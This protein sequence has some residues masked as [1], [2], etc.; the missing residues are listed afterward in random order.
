[1]RYNQNSGYGKDFFSD[2]AMGITGK[3]FIVGNASGVDIDFIRDIAKFD[4]DGKI[5][6]NTTIETALTQCV[7]SRGDVIFVLPGYTE[8][9]TTALT[10][11]VAG[12]K[13][14]GLGQGTLRPALTS[15]GTIDCVDIT[16]DNV[17]FAGFHFPAPETDASTSAINVAGA[18]GVIIRDITG[19]G[20]QTAK[21]VV[22]MITVV[23]SSNDLLIEGVR[24]YNTTVAVNS[25]LSLEGA[26][27]R[28]TVRNF[29]AYGECVT[30]GIIDGALITHL[31]LES[32]KIATT[33]TTIPAVILASNPTGIADGC[34]WSG[35]STTLA[36]NAQLG[37]GMRMFDNL[38]L[39]ETDG[40]KQ[41]ALIPAVDAD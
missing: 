35:T 38:V 31:V 19:I 4:P 26:S 40:S 17:T 2:L 29:V 18:D 6:L 41:G 27:S 30:A 8:T 1:M 37:T 33:G 12:V 7:A 3:V 15:N 20:S 13:L 14:I 11:N 36:N 28:V 23:A 22:D 25:F 16:A 32:V 39:E 21:N 24:F 34:R 9:R 5:R 10:L